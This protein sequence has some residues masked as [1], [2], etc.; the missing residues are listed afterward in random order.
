ML[1][2]THTLAR[3]H[4]RAHTHAHTRTHSLVRVFVAQGELRNANGSTFMGKWYHGKKHGEGLA[5]DK[6]GT[7][8]VEVCYTSIPPPHLSTHTLARSVG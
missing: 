2:L 5:I 6:H 7:A 4:A 3:T 8:S 1:S